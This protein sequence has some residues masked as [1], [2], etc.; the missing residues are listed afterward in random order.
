MKLFGS[1]IAIHLFCFFILGLLGLINSQGEGSLTC[2]KANLYTSDL[3]A[4][5]CVGV[6][7]LIRNYINS[8]SIFMHCVLQIRVVD[9]ERTYVLVRVQQVDTLSLVARWFWSTV[10]ISSLTAGVSR[11]GTWSSAVRHP[12]TEV[13]IH[14]NSRFLSVHS[15]SLSTDWSAVLRSLYRMTSA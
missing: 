14:W 10:V 1:S 11:S 8:V 2:S 15:H 6:E 5:Y 9:R 13:A 4:T 7:S 12:R 3:H